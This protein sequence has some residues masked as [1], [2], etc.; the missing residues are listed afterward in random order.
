M[1][2][3][4][5][6]NDKLQMISRISSS[7]PTYPFPTQLPLLNQINR[8]HGSDKIKTLKIERRSSLY[9]YLPPRSNMSDKN[10][11]NIKHSNLFLFLS[12]DV[13]GIKVG[14]YKGGLIATSTP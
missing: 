10:N 14:S 1:N 11:L 4:T 9:H 8:T 6:T 3:H 13:A 2:K 12:Q 5:F 7:L